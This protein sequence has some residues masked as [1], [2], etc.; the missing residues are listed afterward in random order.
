MSEHDKYIITTPRPASMTHYKLPLDV[1]RSVTWMDSSLVEGACNM[2]CVWY[3]QPFEGPGHHVENDTTEILGF[4]GT[5]KD[6]P[7]D[8]GGVIRFRFEDEWITLTKSCL[9]FIPQGMW[10]CP[11]IVDEVRTPIFHIA[12]TPQRMYAK[13]RNPDGSTMQDKK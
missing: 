7:E 13:R 3:Y 4:F 11:F 2:E 1:R 5:N 12:I 9:I 10:H 8:L 6:D